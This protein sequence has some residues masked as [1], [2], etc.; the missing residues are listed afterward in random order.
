[1]RSRCASDRRVAGDLVLMRAARTQAL[2]RVVLD[3]DA[4][5]RS[6]ILDTLGSRRLEEVRSALP[7]A[8][9]PMRL[10]MVLSESLRD[11][12]GS[13]GA[14][15]AYRAAMTATFDRPLLRNFVNLTAGI[16]GLTPRGILSRSK[17]VYDLVTRGAGTLRHTSLGFL[18]SEVVL[19]RFPA[20]AFSLDCYAEGL[21]GSLL[22]ALDL[23]KLDGT[24]DITRKDP[25]GDVS[26]R[27]S[28]S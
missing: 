21:Q 18:E 6:R 14:I 24:V 9:L 23:C 4:R 26:F 8:W 11:V 2:L 7:L 22:A 27:V 13:T 17:D 3:M 15:S 16:F 5:E 19:E 1:M 25:S 10:H 12:V 28:W 20:G